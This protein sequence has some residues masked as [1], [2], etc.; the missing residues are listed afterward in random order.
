MARF[1][2]PTQWRLRNRILLMLALFALAFGGPFFAPLW[3]WSD[4]D[5]GLTIP[6]PSIFRA[7]T[8]A[9]A[10]MGRRSGGIAVGRPPLDTQASQR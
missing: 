3:E 4:L 8:W 1:V 5:P 9:E 7:G 2:S 6:T 10:R